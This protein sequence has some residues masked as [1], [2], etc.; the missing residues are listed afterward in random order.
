MQTALAVRDVWMIVAELLVFVIIYFVTMLAVLGGFDALAARAVRRAG[1]RCTSWRCAYFVPR[2]GRVARGAGRRALADD[3]PHHRR[4]HQHRHRQAVLARAARGRA[5]RAARCRSS[6]APC[7]RRCA[8]SPA[9]RSSTTCC[10]M[11]LIAATAGVDAVAVDA[12]PG[13]RRRGR[14]RH[15]DGA[16]P[17]RHLALGD[18]G[19]GGAVRAHRHGAGRHQHAVAAARGRRPRRT[20]SRSS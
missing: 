15:R 10:R 1:S 7:T 4:V 19:D 16:A 13:R 5:S 3:R 18:V 12:G 9:S 14:R 2:L 6:W 20:R 8:S 11:A 17:E